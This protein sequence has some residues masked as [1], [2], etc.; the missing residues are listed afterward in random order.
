[1]VWFLLILPQLHA[2]LQADA[3]K[4]T[5]T[6]YNDAGILT[7]KIIAQRG[8]YGHGPAR[9]DDTQIL[10]PIHLLLCI[11]QYEGRKSAVQ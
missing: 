8:S 9:G 4:V 5:R 6:I 1:M 11:Y 2:Q 10:F 7:H 3:E